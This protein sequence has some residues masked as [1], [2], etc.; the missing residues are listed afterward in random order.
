MTS[1]VHHLTASFY[2]MGIV[3][4]S[5]AFPTWIRLACSP[6][7]RDGTDSAHERAHGASVATF[8]TRRTPRG[9]G[10]DR[11]CACAV[12]CAFS[13]RPAQEAPRLQAG[14]EGATA[15]RQRER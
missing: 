7:R 14:E 15:E 3:Q 10:A 9:L 5:C 6:E 11:G 13:Q 4:Q 2:R 12:L 1:P 8:D